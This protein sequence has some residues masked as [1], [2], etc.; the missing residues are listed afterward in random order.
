LK[1][2]KPLLS[3]PSL[4]QRITRLSNREDLGCEQAKTRLFFKDYR[5]LK[6]THLYSMEVFASLL[7]AISQERRD[8]SNLLLSL[9]H[10]GHLQLT[11][12]I[13]K[14]PPSS[15]S[16]Q[17]QF[18]KKSN[19]VNITESATTSNGANNRT[20]KKVNSGHAHV[21]PAHSLSPFA[22]PTPPEIGL[23][24]II[25]VELVSNQFHLGLLL[26]SYR[27][28][29]VV[30]SP[31]NSLFWFTLPSW[32]F[33]V[34]YW[35]RNERFTLTKRQSSVAGNEKEVLL[36]EFEDKM[37]GWADRVVTRLKER[38]N[39]RLHKQKAEL[40]RELSS[41]H[42]SHMEYEDHRSAL[43]RIQEHQEEEERVYQEQQRLLPWYAKLTQCFRRGKK[44][45]SFT[46]GYGP[47]DLALLAK[48][49]QKAR[50]P[51]SMVFGDM[52]VLYQRYIGDYGIKGFRE[53][54]SRPT[55]ETLPHRLEHI[56]WIDRD[57]WNEDAATDSPNKR[58]SRRGYVPKSVV[59]LLGEMLVG[60]GFRSVVCVAR[61]IMD[62]EHYP[63]GTA[64][65]EPLPLYT[66][67]NDP[68]RVA[69]LRSCRLGFQDREL[70]DAW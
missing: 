21:S 48:L 61:A 24:P 38:V 27:Q 3:N 13:P 30:H 54:H 25:R 59:Q 64:I 6:L 34:Y 40:E 33:P 26:R 68:E 2:P 23:K 58:K 67:A 41:I 63:G 55:P 52:S 11:Q 35:G 20:L 65:C 57:D 45:T 51:R 69:Y 9:A 46:P 12:T 18:Q 49:L 39:R 44:I 47:E 42:Q 7:A 37:T 43:R 28:C 56:S 10:G 60:G 17:R 50:P 29:P 14:K 4:F 32:M 1:L 66:M 22:A 5:D 31:T 36:E 53:R 62:L 70:C 19:S 16:K 8:C 15:S